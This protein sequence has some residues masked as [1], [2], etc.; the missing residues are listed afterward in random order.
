VAIIPTISG[1]EPTSSVPANTLKVSWRVFGGPK[2]LSYEK[3]AFDSA[4]NPEAGSL[5]YVQ[6]DGPSSLLP[7]CHSPDMPKEPPG[8]ALQVRPPHFAPTNT[9]LS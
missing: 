9:G 6:L 1:P 4:D 7:S 2:L 3:W 8:R 5:L